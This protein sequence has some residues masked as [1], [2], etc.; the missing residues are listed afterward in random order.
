MDSYTTICLDPY[1]RETDKI[2]DMKKRIKVEQ[3]IK[4]QHPNAKI[5]FD[6]DSVIYQYRESRCFWS[7]QKK[8]L[9]RL[10]ENWLVNIIHIIL[11]IVLK[12]KPYG[13]QVT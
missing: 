8:Y 7:L 12:L 11:K 5:E 4:K 6:G 3:T 10:T 2:R 1:Q 13:L 9:S